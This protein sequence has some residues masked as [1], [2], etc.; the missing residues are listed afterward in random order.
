MANNPIRL[1]REQVQSLAEAEH[2]I[3]VVMGEF[4]KAE[5]CG[6]DCQQLR[7]LVREKLQEIAAIKEHYG[8]RSK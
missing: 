1:T 5:Q 3:S 7:G 4:D 2:Q 6:I 8:P